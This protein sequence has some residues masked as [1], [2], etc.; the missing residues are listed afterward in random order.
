MKYKLVTMIVVIYDEFGND[1]T[2][3]YT[4]ISYL[5]GS[6]TILPLDVSITPDS[7]EFTYDGVEHNVSTYSLGILS[8]YSYPSIS[9]TFIAFITVSTISLSLFLY[10]S[11]SFDVQSK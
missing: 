5:E 10:N 7:N 6:I 8:M 2:F 11:I 4:I 9:E 1:V 3:N